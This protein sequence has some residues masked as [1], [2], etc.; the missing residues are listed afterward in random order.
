MGKDGLEK[1]LGPTAEYLGIGLRDFTRKRAETVAKVFG[2]A[3]SKVQ[4]GLDEEGLVP[5]K[6]L[7]QIVDV[8]SFADDPIEIEYLGCVLALSRSTVARDN[9]G[10]ALAKEVDSLSNYQLGCHYL[11][12]S[13]IKEAHPDKGVKFDIE[14]RP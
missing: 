1:L 6:V 13:S 12:Y 9:R 14:S 7:K 2:N 5:S 4:G 3:A 8:G 10:A 11:I